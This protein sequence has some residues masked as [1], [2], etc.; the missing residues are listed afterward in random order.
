MKNKIVICILG[1]TLVIASTLLVS[2]KNAQKSALLSENIEAYTEDFGEDIAKS[3][4]AYNSKTV[5]WTESTSTRE[6]TIAFWATLAGMGLSTWGA[7]GS[8]VTSIVQGL[9]GYMT[10]ALATGILNTEFATTTNYRCCG[11]G[12]GTCLPFDGYH[13]DPLDC[14][15]KGYNFFPKLGGW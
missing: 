15:E 14:I 2:Y 1:I 11:D 7:L 13:T 3:I 9:A 8:S 10:G 6:Q 12:C 5:T 4:I